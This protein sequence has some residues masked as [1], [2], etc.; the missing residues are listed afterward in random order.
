MKLEKI[1]T[2]TVLAGYLGSISLGLYGC[3]EN[4]PIT[5]TPK[6]VQ[7]ETYKRVRCNETSLEEIA[8]NFVYAINK[9]DL[10][11]L[12][13]Y[14][15]SQPDYTPQRETITTDAFRLLLKQT[16]VTNEAKFNAIEDEGDRAK[17]ILDF[18]RKTFCY[19]EPE[20]PIILQYKLNF[21]MRKEN[22]LWKVYE[23]L[24]R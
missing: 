10:D 21:I 5:H 16:D 17:I 20:K 13:F 7:S 1:L 19:K 12:N 11:V 15:Q 3:G 6:S 24:L 22:G 9:K 18:S 8:K 2:G 23:T 14:L 4:Q